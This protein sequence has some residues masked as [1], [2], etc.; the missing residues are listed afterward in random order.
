MGN[1]DIRARRGSTP[2]ASFSMKPVLAE[3]SLGI[4]LTIRRT[5]E[6]YSNFCSEGI[7]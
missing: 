4:A 1:V 6:G 5:V 2:F 3:S 7:R